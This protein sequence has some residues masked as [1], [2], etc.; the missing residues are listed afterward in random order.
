MKHTPIPSQK[1]WLLDR[2]LKNWD[3][4]GNGPARPSRA[5][6]GSSAI[7]CSD[8]AAGSDVAGKAGGAGTAAAAVAAM[9]VAARAEFRGSWQG[10]VFTLKNGGLPSGKH[11]KKDGKKNTMSNR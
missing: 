1:H 8:A 4:Q 5:F 9:A 6:F 10:E 2:Y 3:Q 11:T 7:S